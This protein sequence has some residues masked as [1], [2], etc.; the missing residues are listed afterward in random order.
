MDSTGS[1]DY[2]YWINYL[3]V[4]GFSGDPT[5]FP[6]DWGLELGFA[7]YNPNIT[8]GIRPLCSFGGNT[9]FWSSTYSNGYVWTTYNVPSST[10]P[11]VDYNIDSDSCRTN[12]VEI[13]YGYPQNILTDQDMNIT[14]ALEP[15]SESSSTASASAE[16]VS[17]DCNDIGAWPGTN[18]MGLNVTRTRPAGYEPSQIYVNKSRNWTI[19]DCMAMQDQMEEP[20]LSCD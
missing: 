17:N 19:P 2:S 6:D 8:V 16:M 7:S 13:G 3:D 15:G 5:I 11:Y 4:W 12:S 18:C 14:L 1:A 9:E 10:A 20:N